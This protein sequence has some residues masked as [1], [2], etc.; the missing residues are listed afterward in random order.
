[1]Y[2]EKYKTDK[3]YMNVKPAPESS[4]QIRLYAHGYEG[5]ANLGD[6]METMYRRM[7]RDYGKENVRSELDDGFRPFFIL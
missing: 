4:E 3:R 6:D 7:Q 2:T 1:M 5:M